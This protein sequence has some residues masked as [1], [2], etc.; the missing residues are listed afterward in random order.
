MKKILEHCNFLR[1][2]SKDL[3]FNPHLIAM[4]VIKIQVVSSDK[5]V[6]SFKVICR[7]NGRNLEKFIKF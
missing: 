1:L 5:N 2:L 3:I 7:L 6:G 4:A